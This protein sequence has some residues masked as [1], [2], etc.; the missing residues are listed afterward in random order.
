MAMKGHSIL[1]DIY[2]NPS[3]ALLSRSEPFGERI[4]FDLMSSMA[5]FMSI[6]LIAAVA[7]LAL[8]LRF[9]FDMS[10]LRGSLMSASLERPGNDAGRSNAPLRQAHGYA[11]DLLD[12][13]ADGV[14]RVRRVVDVF[15]DVGWFA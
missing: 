3:L 8:Q 13:P 10:L 7:F 1:A 4:L 11:A 5:W 14:W 6:A 9:L 15:W 2:I 12:R